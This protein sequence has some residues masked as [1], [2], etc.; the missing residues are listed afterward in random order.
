MSTEELVVG[1]AI[2]IFIV[3]GV[4]NVVLRVRIV[5]LFFRRLF[6]MDE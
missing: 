6:G 3:A 4:W 1:A 2:L 5:R